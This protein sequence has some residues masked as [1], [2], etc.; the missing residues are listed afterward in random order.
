MPP[1]FFSVSRD[2]PGGDELAESNRDES[3]EAEGPLPPVVARMVVEIRSD[4]TRTIA[5]GAI[6]DLQTGERVALQAGAHSPVALARELTKALLKTPVLASDLAKR[7]VKDLLP[8]SLVE[9]SAKWNPLRSKKK[10]P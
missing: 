8:S 2:R 5:R 7:A 4:G 1:R 10:G 9:K 3:L 6:E